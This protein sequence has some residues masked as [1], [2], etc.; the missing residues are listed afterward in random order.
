MLSPPELTHSFCCIACTGHIP[1]TLYGDEIAKVTTSESVV[2][3]YAN[4]V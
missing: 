1:W 3:L 4:V 2:Y